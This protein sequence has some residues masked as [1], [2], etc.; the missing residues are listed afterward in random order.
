MYFTPFSSVSRRRRA[1]VIP[2][3]SGNYLIIRIRTNYT[4]RIYSRYIEA[5]ENTFLLC[6]LVTCA[7]YILG[8]QTVK[9]FKEKITSLGPLQQASYKWGSG[10]ARAHAE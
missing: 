4:F 8:G 2:Y 5:N 9:L 3:M 10:S 1:N 7:L 6:I